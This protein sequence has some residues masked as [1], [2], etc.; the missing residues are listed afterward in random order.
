MTSMMSCA[1]NLCPAEACM[2]RYIQ[3]KVFNGQCPMKPPVQPGDTVT[4]MVNVFSST[5]TDQLIVRDPKYR[6][7]LRSVLNKRVREILL[8]AF[9]DYFPTLM[10]AYRQEQRVGTPNQKSDF[11]DEGVTRHE[12]NSTPGTEGSRGEVVSP[13][14]R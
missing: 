5:I 4:R 1:S 3:R 11:R 10:R 12:D 14:P 9:H 8:E 7:I 6:R 13:V 2:C